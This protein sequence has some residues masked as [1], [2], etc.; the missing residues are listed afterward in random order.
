M[1]KLQDRSIVEIEYARKTFMATPPAGTDI[2]EM[3]SPD[4]WAHVA[5]R[6]TPHDIIEVV[7]E[8]GAFYARLF[9]VNRNKLWAKVQVLDMHKI[10]DAKKSKIKP[11]DVLEAK[12]TGPSGK[13]RVFY[14]KDGSSASEQTF[15]T[16]DDASTWIEQ[17]GKELAA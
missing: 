2:K 4:Y 7:P 12:Y 9:V 8:D 13:W 14:K 6:L 5:S 1:Q 3:L 10:I 16:Q 11:D 15:Q 17:N